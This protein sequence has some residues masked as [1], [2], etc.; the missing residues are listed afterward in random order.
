MPALGIE[1]GDGIVHVFCFDSSFSL[2]VHINSY[3]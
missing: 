1:G 3:F 2:G